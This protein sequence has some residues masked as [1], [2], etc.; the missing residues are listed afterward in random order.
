MRDDD[1]WHISD[2]LYSEHPCGCRFQ[3]MTIL[4]M[5]DEH[6]AKMDARVAELKR[7]LERMILAAPE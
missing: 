6:Q 4:G 1:G 2:F 3:G 5:C 7:E